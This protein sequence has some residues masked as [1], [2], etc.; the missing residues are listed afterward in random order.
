MTILKEATVKE[1]V[2]LKNFDKLK[3]VGSLSSWERQIY[4]LITQRL[5]RYL[6]IVMEKVNKSL[7]DNADPED[8]KTTVRIAL[9][10]Y[11]ESAF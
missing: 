3:T 8:V 1:F 2:D 6:D 9:L 7:P 5:S 10:D 11:I 4:N